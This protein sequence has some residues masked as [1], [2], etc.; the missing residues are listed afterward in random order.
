MTMGIY[1]IENTVNGKKYVGKSKTI[2]HRFNSHKYNL[3]RGNHHNRYLQ[4]SYNKYGKKVFI[5]YT[6]E[7]V[8]DIKLLSIKEMNWIDHLGTLDK[9]IGYNLLYDSPDGYVIHESTRK[10]RSLQNSGEMNPNFGNHWTDEQKEAMSEIAKGRHAKGIY[11]EEWRIKI[12][13]AS[14]KTWQD[15]EKKSRMAKAVS[16]SKSNSFF[17]QYDKKTGEF[18]K[19]WN[20]IEEILNE[21]TGWKWQN[22]YAACNGSKKSY[23]GYSWERLPKILDFRT[24]DELVFDEDMEDDFEFLPLELQG[25]QHLTNPRTFVNL[26]TWSSKDLI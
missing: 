25:K 3:K 13:E 26:Y 6:L 8:D 5:Y 17:R 12:G 24:A 4:Y 11:G 7:V 14:S 15:E 16:K 20:S 21:N 23:M 10:L 18:I 1:C 2:E 19:K 9:R 22:I